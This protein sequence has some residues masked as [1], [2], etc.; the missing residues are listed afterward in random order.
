MIISDIDLKFEL[1]EM[2]YVFCLWL[3]EKGFTTATLEYINQ[4]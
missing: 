2:I 1:V 4:S 3:K